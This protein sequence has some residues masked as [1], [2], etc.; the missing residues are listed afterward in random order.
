MSS[1]KII[2]CVDDENDILE[3]FRDEF[4][5]SGF[6]VLEASNGAEAFEL[7][8]NNKILA[9]LKYHNSSQFPDSPLQQISLLLLM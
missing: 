3:L 7:F 2:L 6:K 8:Q 4:I 1:E 5:D 9:R